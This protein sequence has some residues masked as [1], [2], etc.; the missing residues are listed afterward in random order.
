MSKTVDGIYGAVYEIAGEAIAPSSI[1]VEDGTLAAPSICFSS[2]PD[3]GLHLDPLGGPYEWSEAGMVADWQILDTSF[4]DAVNG[5]DLTPYSGTRVMD[6]NS[7][8]GTIELPGSITNGQGVLLNTV[9]T[10][11]WF[12]GSAVSLG[13]W[14]KGTAEAATTVFAKLRASSSTN[15]HW[16]ISD[17]ALGSMSISVRDAAG[18]IL[19]QVDDATVFDDRWHHIALVMTKTSG[20][21]VYLDGVQY[22]NGSYI[23]GTQSTNITLTTL[24]NAVYYGGNRD[25]IEFGTGL[26]SLGRMVISTTAWTAQDVLDFKNDTNSARGL[27]I[28]SNAN[29]LIRVRSDDVEVEING[30][31]RFRV[32]TSQTLIRDGDATNPGIGFLND[33]GMGMARINNELTLHNNG[34]T[35]MELDNTGL[36]TFPVGVSGLIIPTTGTVLSSESDGVVLTSGS[37]SLSTA[38]TARLTASDSLLISTVP[39]RL[40]NGNESSP[41]YSFINA[42]DTGVYNGTCLDLWTARTTQLW[43]IADIAYSSTLEVLVAVGQAAYIQASIDGGVTWTIALN[44]AAHG[45]TAVA[46]SPSLA[47]FVAVGNSVSYAPYRSSLGTSGWTTSGATVLAGRNTDIIWASSINLFI[48]TRNSFGLAQ[49]IYTS[50]DGIIFTI[51]TTPQSGTNW[52]GAAWSPSLGLAVVVASSGA[53]RVMTSTDGIVWT[54]GTAIPSFG[55][56]SVD[57]SVDLNLFCAVGDAGA[58]MTSTD[59]VVWTTQTSPNSN[60]H[61]KVEWIPDLYKFVVCSDSG[62]NNRVLS[63]VDGIIWRAHA[64]DPDLAF[65]SLGW[66]SYFNTLVMV[67]SNASGQDI[68]TS[69]DSLGFT[70]NGTEQLITCGNETTLNTNLVIPTTGSVL[71]PGD[72][73]LVLTSGSAA[74]TTNGAARLTVTDTEITSTLGLFLPSTGATASSL[75][76]HAAGTHT[77]DWTGAFTTDQAGTIAWTRIGNVVTLVVAPET[78]GADTATTIE[79]VTALPAYLRPTNDVEVIAIV[80]DNA[81]FAVGKAYL[82]GGIITFYASVSG[83]NFVGTGATGFRSLQTSYTIDN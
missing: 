80:Y 27:I 61:E 35:G 65:T 10:S 63:S 21:A 32:D 51:R 7:Y 54:L 67:S 73:G 15:G 77:T 5:N 23:T 71:N 25:N 56:K 42:I 52:E 43:Q 81:T 48:V 19:V 28:S 75:N 60:N 62:T 16:T 26:V 8:D 58:I 20:N 74:L 68:V 55:W 17:N 70:A 1:C 33:T 4:V 2:D 38:G 47:L 72:D 30:V 45:M 44:A 66:S 6:V 64:T 37:V 78:A 13:F 39:L 57:W 12:T 9:L 82:S 83:A 31:K 50:P 53:Q 36:V 29:S 69:G 76:F 40:A 14:M 41:S 24:V 46:W 34:V 79:N 3:A 49:S 59:G 22:P 18:T 11:S